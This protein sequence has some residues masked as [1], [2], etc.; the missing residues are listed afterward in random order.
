MGLHTNIFSGRRLAPLRPAGDGPA[1]SLLL[2][3]AVGLHHLALLRGD[4]ML[5]LAGLLPGGGS[6]DQ[7][8]GGRS[9]EGGGLGEARG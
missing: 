4:D 5:L 3:R 6:R 2:V 9:T 8:S 1:G 7:I